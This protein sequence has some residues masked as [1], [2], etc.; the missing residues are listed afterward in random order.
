MTRFKD[1]GEFEFID[2]IAAHT[3]R[4]RVLCGIGDDCAVIAAG[5]GRVRLVTT[6]AMVEGV[7]F[8]QNAPP[9]SV[10]YK[11]LTASL[12]D[13]AAMG[14]KP[15][16]AV[17]AV[18]A[19]EG[20]DAGYVERIYNGLF[21]CADQFGVA[22]VGGDTTR[23]AGPLVLSLT[24][25]GTMARDQVSYRSGAR[26]GDAIYV[27]GTLGDAAGGLG[28]ALGAVEMQGEDRAALLRR[29][30]RPKARVDLG[31]ALAETDAVTAMI[32]VSD[33]L[34]SDLN[35]ICR[36]SGVSAVIRAEAIPMSAAFVK[37]CAAS[38]ENKLALAF[39]GG[40]DFELLFCV[41]RAR[42]HKIEALATRYSISRIGEIAAGNGGVRIEGED[43]K[44]V[45]LKRVGYEHFRG[46]KQ[47]QITTDE[48]G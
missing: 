44:R 43:G 17:V 27:S 45:L 28:V 41:H 24:L 8:V 22:I 1:I 38:R 16:D 15:T 3:Q 19:S 21:A 32:D 4:N 47:P 48:R 12:S 37:F 40:E 25:T 42:V 23:T 10:G 33:G 20:C 39:T 26:V 13:I 2:R 36:Q 11:L 30:Y 31:R 29:H 5:K 35:H 34:A 7:H 9:E 46:E 18:G 6:D 14:G